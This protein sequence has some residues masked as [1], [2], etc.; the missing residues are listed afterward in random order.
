MA[1]EFL[2]E[3][4]RAS[5]GDV[6]ASRKRMEVL[7]GLLVLKADD[8]ALSLAQRLVV[9]DLVPQEF[10]ADA[11]HIAIAAVNGIDCLL[12]WNCKHLANAMLREKIVGL[13]NH[14]GYACPVICTPE[15][16][17]EE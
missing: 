13:V 8:A 7:E 16:L 10:A 5:G 1:N 2:I 14:V 4:G 11:L 17:M 12:T 3:G 6:D 9:E 15:E